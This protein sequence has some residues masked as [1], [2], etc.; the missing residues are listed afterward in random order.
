MPRC[1]LLVSV[2]QLEYGFFTVRAASYL[3]PDR[4]SPGVEA[5]GQGNGGSAGQV[6]DAGVKERK[7]QGVLLTGDD[8][9]ILNRQRRSARRGGHQGVVPLQG[10]VYF[11]PSQGSEILRFVICLGRD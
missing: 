1:A 8:G 6:E 3:Q 9:V 11:L 2:C 4:E 7:A 10:L 5:T